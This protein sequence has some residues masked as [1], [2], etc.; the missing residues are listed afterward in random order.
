MT[1]VAKTKRTKWTRKAYILRS[2]AADMTSRGGTFTWPASGMVEA[3]DWKPTKVCGNGLHGFLN[4]DG[5]GSLASFHPDAKWL[6]AE[7]D[8]WIDLDGKVKFPRA[9]VVFCG[10]RHSAPAFLAEQGIKG[11]I[12]GGTAT[13]GYG[14]TATAGYGG[15]ATAGYGGTATAGYGGTATAGVSG[16]V[17]VKW[18]DGQA[19]RYRIATGY[20][21][22]Q[23]IE[24]N[25]PYRCDAGGKLVAA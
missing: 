6:V 3:A 8:E 20:V 25:R 12:V 9:K 7:I 22:E 16:T 1:S 19:S 14:G 2:C 15:T 24:A 13:A 17:Q 11:V 4:G 5:D 18:W 21:G 10:D 23:G